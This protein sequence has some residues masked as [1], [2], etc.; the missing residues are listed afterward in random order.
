MTSIVPLYA[1]KEVNS[2]HSHY[3]GG[4]IHSLLSVAQPVLGHAPEITAIHRRKHL[5]GTNF[6]SVALQSGDAH[7]LDWANPNASHPRRHVL[8]FMDANINAFN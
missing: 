4:R 6:F 7:R 2:P 8:G 5:L 1:Q 3:P